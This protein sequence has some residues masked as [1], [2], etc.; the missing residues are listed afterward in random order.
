MKE[1]L[2]ALE[3]A[4][5][6]LLRTTVSAPAEGVVTKTSLIGSSAVFSP[7]RCQWTSWQAGRRVDT[8]LSRPHPDALN[9]GGEI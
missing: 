7:I 4:Q 1:A 6:D 3:S 5:L 8:S 2:A 9:E